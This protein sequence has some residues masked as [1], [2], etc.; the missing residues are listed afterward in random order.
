[1]TSAHE[2]TRAQA[3]EEAENAGSNT[4]ANPTLGEVIA[5]RFSRRDL[6]RGALAVTAI[7]ATV[8]PLALATAERARAADGN[9]TPSFNFQEVTAGSDEKHY[10]AEGYDADILIRWGDPVVPG[11]PAFDPMKQTADAQ[12]KQFGYNNDFVG[13]FPLPNAANPNEHGLLV[14]NHE[15][16]NEELMFPGLGRQDT[17]QANFAA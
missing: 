12:A 11:A 13:Y 17:K 1:V 5:T 8:S 14:V 3:A 9:T 2:P 4:S 6:L 10:V 15:Y 16:T 7:S